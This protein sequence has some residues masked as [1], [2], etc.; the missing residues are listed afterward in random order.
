MSG[1]TVLTIAHR[2]ETIMHCDRV[3]VMHEGRVAEAGPPQELR[4]TPGSKFA[5]LWEART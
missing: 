2:L 3:V 4:T 5:E 1:T